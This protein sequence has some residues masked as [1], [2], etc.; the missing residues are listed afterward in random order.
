MVAGAPLEPEGEMHEVG[1][2]VGRP[3]L[4]LEAVT[5]LP[6]C[7]LVL[8]SHLV[9]T[10]GRGGEWDPVGKVAIE[11]CLACCGCTCYGGT[12]YGERTPQPNV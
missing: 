6:P 9:A 4:Q 2:G 5:P 8:C 1:V 11:L 7:A 10:A 3:P 12:Y